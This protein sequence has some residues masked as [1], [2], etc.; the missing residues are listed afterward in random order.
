[1][2]TRG[3]HGAFLQFSGL[4]RALDTECRKAGPFGLE[5]SE[6]SEQADS[7]SGCV[8]LRSDRKCEGGDSVEQ[9]GVAQS[10]DRYTKLRVKESED[11]NAMF[12]REMAKSTAA[13][14]MAKD[15]VLNL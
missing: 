7:T 13:A 1:M 12:L 14:N 4:L 9:G 10:S 8:D 2:F 5:S 11:K 3:K 15:G 6:R